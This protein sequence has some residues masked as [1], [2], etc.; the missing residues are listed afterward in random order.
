L[1][2]LYIILLFIYS[3]HIYG[4]IFPYERGIDFHFLFSS[5]SKQ[6]S[7]KVIIIDKK[8]KVLDSLKST[9][10]QVFKE[11]NNYHNKLIEEGRIFNQLHL[12][13][14]KKTDKNYHYYYEISQNEIQKID[15]L[16]Y[17]SNKRFPGNIK[18][19]IL[20]LHFHRALSKKNLIKIEKKLNAFVPEITRQE[21]RPVIYRSKTGA[22]IR[23]KTDFNNFLE[24]ELN[25]SFQNNKTILQGFLNLKLKNIINQTEDLSLYWRKESTSQELKLSSFFPYLLGSS[26]FIKGTYHIRQNPHEKEWI[27]QNIEAGWIKTSYQIGV[28][29]NYLLN[30]NRQSHKQIGGRFS[31]MP[32][33]NPLQNLYLEKSISLEVRQN[34]AGYKNSHLNL[35]IA[36]PIHL[37]SK[38]YLHLKNY[39]MYNSNKVFFVP[40][41]KE[42]YNYLNGVSTQPTFNR[43]EFINLKILSKYKQSGIYLTSSYLQSLELQTTKQFEVGIGVLSI[44]KA[45]LLNVELIY[46]KNTYSRQ[47]QNGF[48]IKINQ[49]IRI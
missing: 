26:I 36:I 2:N 25:S 43:F 7:I 21:I 29:Y 9:E 6:D 38:Y 35:T 49:K 32:K 1:K 42:F 22:S 11:I 24:G 37:S 47:T 16:I 46:L 41:T 30:E 15:T 33:N 45:Q 39:I 40:V 44:G 5:S 28:T 23:I 8:G 27:K 10:K 31:W 19:K 14:I 3:S 13:K 20:K 4:Q 48:R 18:K 34:L 12:V 17:L